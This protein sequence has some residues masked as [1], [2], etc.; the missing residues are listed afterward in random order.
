MF[1]PSSPGPRTLYGAGKG[2]NRG[3]R[4]MALIE[5]D[6][7]DGEEGDD[8]EEDSEGED[9]SE[10]DEAELEEN[11]GKA[12]LNLMGQIHK[13]AKKKEKRTAAP[14]DRISAFDLSA[15]PEAGTV[16][17]LPAC[18]EEKET[19]PQVA[20]DK[21]AEAA[22][23]A[24][25]EPTVVDRNEKPLGGG[26]DRN[27]KPLGGSSMTAEDLEKMM[28]VRFVCLGGCC[29]VCARACVVLLRVRARA[30][31]GVRA[32]GCVRACL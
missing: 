28:L 32:R 21:A 18:K 15:L 13:S 27:E 20:T 11:P 29:F 30:S 26:G 19:P 2:G 16:E 31:A 4:G 10:E 12:R 8:T 5:I 22:A 6:E 14:A 24:P 9:D 23:A 3:P 1:M 7:S 25:A 17:P